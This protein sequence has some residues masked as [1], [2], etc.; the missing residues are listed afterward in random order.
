MR[1]LLQQEC[2]SKNLE[3]WCY[4]T[5]ACLNCSHRSYDSVFRER[6]TPIYNQS[7]TWI[8]LCMDGI[9]LDWVSKIEPM[10]NSVYNLI[11]IT[12]AILMNDLALIRLTIP[13]GLQS[14]YTPSYL[15]ALA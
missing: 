3:I 15:G 14:I 2:E 11:Y 4:A 6:S 5:P 8:G 12:Q 13:A 10:S 7:W 1:T 9:A